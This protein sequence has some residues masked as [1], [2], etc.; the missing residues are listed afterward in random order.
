M[1]Q[2]GRVAADEVT[3]CIERYLRDDVV[4]GPHP[5]AQA[6]RRGALTRSTLLHRE[7]RRRPPSACPSCLQQ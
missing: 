3:R 4:G 6:V 1:P 5:A 2:R 7:Y